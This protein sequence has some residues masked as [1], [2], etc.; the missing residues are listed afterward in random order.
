MPKRRR[1]TPVK[2]KAKLNQSNANK[3]QDAAKLNKDKEQDVAK[4]DKEADSAKSVE[5]EIEVSTPRGRLKGA[6]LDVLEPAAEE[7]DASIEQS[8]IKR[9]RKDY[10]SEDEDRYN[11]ASSPPRQSY[12]LKLFDRSVDLSQFSEDSP[13]YPICR[14]WITNQPKAN[15]KE[16]GRR[17]DP[18][19]QTEDSVELPG[20]EGPPISRIPELIPEQLK[21]N[22]DNI[23]LNYRE[24][25]PPSRAQLLEGHAARWAGVRGAWLRRAARV[26]ARYAAA[27]RLLNEINVNAM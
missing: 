9:E 27:Q 25:V 12:V 15:Y 5:I 20:P 22:K 7:S 21:R 10:T 14:A 26:E 19:E 11:R 16:F 18:P 24:A 3:A 2:S 6:L 1:L 23:N 4:W 17:S 13:L 8:P